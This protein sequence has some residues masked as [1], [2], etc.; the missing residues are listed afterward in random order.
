MNKNRFLLSTFIFT[1][2][3]ILLSA[4][5][6]AAMKFKGRAMVGQHYSGPE[7]QMENEYY[8]MINKNDLNS[9]LS[10]VN[11]KKLSIRDSKPEFKFDDEKTNNQYF[12]GLEAD[13]FVYYKVEDFDRSKF[14]KKKNKLF[15]KIEK[16]LL[17]KKAR[18]EHKKYRDIKY[19]MTEWDI[20]GNELGQKFFNKKKFFKVKF[21]DKNGKKYTARI[22]FAVFLNSSS[23]GPST[24]PVSIPEPATMLLLG[25]GLIG[26]AGMRRRLKK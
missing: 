13:D 3:L 14:E 24:R 6:S 19:D 26:L 21:K 7:G 18:E 9:G 2:G 25:V 22:P 8:L 15:A 16:K 1:M 10:D 17:R 23:R 11:L 5:P 20:W 4:G 12:D